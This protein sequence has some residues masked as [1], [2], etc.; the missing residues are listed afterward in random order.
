MTGRHEQTCSCQPKLYLELFQTQ[1]YFSMLQNM[2]LSNVYVKGL[3]T[4]LM[5]HG[6]MKLLGMI[7]STKY[8]MQN[9]DPIAVPES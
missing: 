8:Q 6:S 1:T 5:T 7:N 3:G 2:C 9:F 4:T